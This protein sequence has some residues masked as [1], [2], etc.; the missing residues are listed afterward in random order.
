MGNKD[1]QTEVNYGECLDYVRR[2]SNPS[3]LRITDVKFTKVDLPPWGCSLVRIDTNQGI[4][5]YG[6][7]RDGASPKYLKYLKSRIMGENPCEVDRIFR[8]IK[9]FGGPARQ[10]A[11]VCAV[12]LALWDL[13]GKAYGVPV[14]QLLG[15]RFREKVRLYADTHIEEGRATG[16]LMEPEKV[17]RILKGYMDQGFTVVK[18]LSVELLMAQ[19]GNTCGPLDWVDEL[20]AVEEKVRQVTRTGTRAESSAA[21]ALLYD[22]NRIPHPFTNMHVTEQGLDQLDEYI[23][24]VRSVI[25]TKVPLAIDHFGHFPLPDMIKIARRLEKYHLAWLED[26]LPWYLTDQY[27]ELKHATTAPIATGEDM[28]L[29]ESF[30]PLLQAG[31]L[32]VVHPDLLTSGGILETKKLGDLAARYGAS[33]ALHMCES[34]VSALAG[35]HMATA[36]EN[37]F[38]QE[39]DAFD[40]EWWQDL[41]I[42]P[43]KPIVKDGFTVITDA[44]GLGIEGLNEDLIREHGPMKGKD[45]WVSTDEWNQ[46]TSLD[47]IWS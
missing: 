36:S 16:I 8:K 22:F 14:Y 9:Q 5:G 17:G 30:E 42:G 4:S 32:D 7:M 19:E 13:A 28:Y 45:V 33:M 12:E 27:R 47:R 44:P 26:M 43:V 25:G 2:S 15:G 10:A 1:G 35:A 29:A 31:A 11:G 24:R 20:R 3:K 18:I 23:G 40:S 34:P 41:I 39:H 46:E 38:A 21:N 37:F 6:E